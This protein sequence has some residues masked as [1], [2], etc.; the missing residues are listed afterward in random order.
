MIKAEIIQNIANKTGI[1]KPTVTV[2]VESLMVT[3]KQSMID[4]NN[5]YLRGF[6][7]FILKKRAEKKGRNIS[8]GTTVQIP[9][10]VIPVFRPSEEFENQVKTKVKVK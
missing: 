10:H 4:G 5:I 2:I 9:A 8:K 3:M 7:T 1:E 6:G